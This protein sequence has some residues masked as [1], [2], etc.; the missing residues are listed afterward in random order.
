[1]R[2]ILHLAQAGLRMASFEGANFADDFG[3]PFAPQLV[4][5]QC[6]GTFFAVLCLYR[7]DGR[8]QTEPRCLEAFR[9]ARSS[10]IAD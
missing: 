8:F 3:I 5:A 7:S 2:E 4:E 6:P 1:M 9:S 10:R